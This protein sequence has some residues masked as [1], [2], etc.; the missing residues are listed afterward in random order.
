MTKDRF[1]VIPAVHIFLLKDD[2]IL[3]LRRFNTGYQDGNYSVLAG[4]LD[5]DEDVIAAAQRE[6]SEEAGITIN[7]QDL[8][9][10]GVIHR[11]SV[12]ERIDFFLVADKWTGEITNMEPAKCDELDWYPLKKLPDNMIPYV[13]KA[14]D[15]YMEDKLFDV[16]GF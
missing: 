3:L 5:G 2:Q 6:A 1:K 15:N 11:K 7:Y 10:V 8:R 13:R 4:H 12:E 14:I 16:Y 9:V